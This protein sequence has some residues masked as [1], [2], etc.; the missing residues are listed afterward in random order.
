MKKEKYLVGVSNTRNHIGFIW[1]QANINKTCTKTKN[2]Y[3]TQKRCMGVTLFLRR[4]SYGE[5]K[6]YHPQK[7][8]NH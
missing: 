7:Q 5:I 4:L 3:F 8:E 1:I 6:V 2:N